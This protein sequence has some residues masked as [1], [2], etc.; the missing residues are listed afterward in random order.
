MDTDES[1]IKVVSDYTPR[2]ASGYKAPETML[3][4]VSGKQ[5]PIGE[6][7]EHMRIQFLDPRW[8]EEQKR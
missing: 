5:V 6:M 8:R 3:D 1:E 7:D 4:P 2:V